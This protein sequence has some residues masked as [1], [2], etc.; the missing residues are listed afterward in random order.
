MDKANTPEQQPPGNRKRVLAALG[1]FTAAAA[2][3]AGAP[4]LLPTLG[5]LGSFN[6]T[7][8]FEQA[9]LGSSWFAAWLTVAP[10]SVAL[11]PSLAIAAIGAALV[12]GA[13]FI[14]IPGDSTL[15]VWSTAAAAQLSCHGGNLLV[16]GSLGAMSGAARR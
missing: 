5:A 14:W 2:L 11:I 6:T 4:L 16:L 7:P 15:F 12:I 1:R 10:R 8:F 9:V 3:V 13:Y